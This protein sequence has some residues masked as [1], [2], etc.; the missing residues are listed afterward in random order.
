MPVSLVLAV[1]VVALF[2]LVGC[3]ATTPGAAAPAQEATV[4]VVAPV[5]TPTATKKDG[6]ES[7]TR[8]KGEEGEMGGVAEARAARAAA[9]RDAAEFGLEGLLNSGAIPTGVF[10]GSVGGVVGGVGGLGLSGVGIGGGGGGIGLGS[11]GG[12]GT[13]S[14]GGGTGYGIGSSRASSS[15]SPVSGQSVIAGPTSVIEIGDA[16]TLGVSLDVAVR[17]V[18]ERVYRVRDCYEDRL[19]SKPT[20]AGSLALRVVLARDGRVVLT[21]DLGSDLADPVTFTCIAKVFEG[22]Y[23]GVPA[24]GDFGVIETVLRFRRAPKK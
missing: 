10:G 6:Q 14:G 20:L 24:G 21:R 23:V 1:S 8:S 5:V 2:A 16:A 19:S 4:H 7:G 11:M 18:R 15:S 12:I 9:L 17:L 3:G 13:G 22:V